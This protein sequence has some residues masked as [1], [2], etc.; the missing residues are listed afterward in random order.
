MQ[1]VSRDA[2]DI[3]SVLD[4][5]RRVVKAL[6]VFSRSAQRR[7]GVTGA[8]LFVLKSLRDRAP[9]SMSQLAAR[10]CTHQSTVS[11]VV[12]RL[13]RDGLVVSTYAAADGR[14]VELCLTSAGRARLRKAPQTAQEGLIKGLER[15]PRAVRTRLAGDLHQLIESMQLGDSTPAMFFEDRPRRVKRQAVST[16]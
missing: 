10:T 1:S 5:L 4:D 7:I 11:V 2:L 8:Q 9:L 3:Q 12:K 13:V 15:L 16:P 14:R 6:G